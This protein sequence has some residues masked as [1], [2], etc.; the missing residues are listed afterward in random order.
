MDEPGLVWMELQAELGES[1]REQVED[2]VGILSFTKDHDEIVGIPDQ[3]GL[4]ESRGTISFSN[5][6]S[7]TV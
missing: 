1:L 5:H 6:S 4:G 2:E 3:V 7:R